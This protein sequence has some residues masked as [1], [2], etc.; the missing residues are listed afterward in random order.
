[1]T[2][3]RAVIAAAALCACGSE[4]GASARLRIPATAPT[5]PVTVGLQ[6]LQLG[7]VR[8]GVLYVPTSYVAGEPLP[9]LV[10]L[11]GAGGDANDWFGSYAQR[12]E[13]ARF[14]MLAPDSRGPTWDAI[15]GKFAEDVSFI[16]SA[17]EL[18]ASEVA[19]DRTRMAVV[20][21]SDGATYSLSLGLA[22]GDLFTH[23]IAY[24]PGFIVSSTNRGTPKFFISH[25]K[26]DPILPIARTS[27][28]IVSVFRS[29]GYDV[30]YVEF[31]GGHE[32]P[33][34]ISAQAVGWLQADWSPTPPQGKRVSRSSSAR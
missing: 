7:G 14:V 31:D 9:L 4:D 3:L 15:R 20:G 25:G 30:H 29:R 33:L 28:E 17:L 6:P 26:Q 12:A 19:I 10:L 16:N 1:M 11:H 32:V 13:D 18:V 2:R 8:D 23:V 21:F 22:N 27:R 24:S 5:R 34:D